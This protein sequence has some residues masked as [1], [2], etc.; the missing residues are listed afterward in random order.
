VEELLIRKNWKD[1]LPAQRAFP[2]CLLL[3]V[4]AGTRFTAGSASYWIGQS[5]TCAHLLD[6]ASVRFD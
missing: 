3:A 6:E 1:R 4:R 2:G 5:F